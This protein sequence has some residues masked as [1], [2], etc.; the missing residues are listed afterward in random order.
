MLSTAVVISAL[1]LILYMEIC[2]VLKKINFQIWKKKQH[3]LVFACNDVG[4]P[5]LIVL[6]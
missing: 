2:M 3:L 1:K 5:S 6:K 4:S